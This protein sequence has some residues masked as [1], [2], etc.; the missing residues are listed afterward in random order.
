MTEIEL[1]QI[2]E[3]LKE[4]DEVPYI[5]AKVNLDDLVKIGE[6]ISAVSNSASYNNEEYGYLIFGLKDKNWVVIGTNFDLKKKKKGNQD[7]TLWLLNSLNQRYFEVFDFELTDKKLQVLK[8]VNCENTPIKFKNEAFIRIN[9]HNQKLN[10]YNEIERAIWSKKPNFDWSAQICEAATMEDL[11][12]EALEIAK[13]GYTAKQSKTDED[14]KRIREYS[15]QIFLDEA[16][17]TTNGKI[18]NAAILLLGKEKS[19]HYLQ[20][21]GGAEIFWREMTSFDDISFKIPFVK[22]IQE[23]VAKITTR[24]IELSLKVLGQPMMHKIKENYSKSTLREC[25]AN[26]VA[27]QDYEK[28]CRILIYETRNENIRFEN[29]G[30]CLYSKDEF[31]Q[32]R[33]KKKIPNNYRNGFLRNA[34]EQIGLIEAKGTGHHKIYQYNT[35]EVYLPLPEVDW[36]NQ[37]D[38]ILT[39]YGASLDEKFAEILQ[40]KTDLEPEAILLLDQVQKGFRIDQK[41][42]TKLKKQG[43][44]EGSPTK[45]TLSLEMASITNTEEQT[46]KKN[47]EFDFRN[48]FEASF[49]PHLQKRKVGMTKQEIISFAL[50]HIKY[51]V[52]MDEKKLKSDITNSLTKLKNNTQ[53]KPVGNSDTSIK[54]F[55]I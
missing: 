4:N 5:E 54:W 27:H 30:A 23:V 44:V 47:Q 14:K 31:N 32:I 34:M 12:E 50:N 21:M 25:V 42:F 53:I 15:N 39:L 24:N 38:F 51:A 9:S 8:V 48:I 19:Q 11:D 26:C 36:N 46:D 41:I 35:T 7:A 33:L 3:K 29:V 55:K 18:T 2:I 52:E 20:P 49:L 17:I 22:S 28:N 45:A 40:Q 16:R 43:L 10:D 37:K 13:I 6:T 1:L